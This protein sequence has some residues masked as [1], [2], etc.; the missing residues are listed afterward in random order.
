MSHRCLV[1]FSSLLVIP[2]AYSQTAAPNASP[3]P[4]F[5]SKVRAV[6]VDVVVIG[7]KGEPVLGLHKQDFRV[8]EDGKPQ[9]ISSFEEHTGVPP[10]EVKLP[11][12]PPGVFTNF[13]ALLKADTVNVLLVD[14]LNTQTQ[15]Q[16]FSRSQMIKYLK[17]I[18]PGAHIAIFTLTSQL[19]M[20]QEFTTDSSVLLAALNDPAVAGPHQSPLLQSQ[21]EKDAY[22]RLGAMVALAPSA[23]MQNLAKEA[24]NPA[25]AVKQMLEETVVRITESR[26][27]ITL[28][29]M[30]QLGRYLGSFPGRKN[31]IWISGSFPINFMA[32][33]SLPDPNAVVRGFQGEIQRTAD[34]LTAAQVAV[35]PV[36]AAGLRVDALYQANAKEIGFYSTGGFVQDQVQGLHAGI[37]ERAG[38][39]LTM[40]E[41]AKDTGGQAFYNSNGI[42]DV[43]TR[44]TNNGMR[45]YEISYTSTNTKVDGSYRHISVELLKGKHKLSY[46]RG[47]YALDAAAVRQSELEAAPDPLLPLVGFAVPDVAQILYKLR[48]LPSSPQPAVDATPAGS[49]RDLKGPV[50]RYDVDFAVAPDDLKYDIGPDGTRHGDVEVKLVAYDSSGKPVNMV[51]GRKAMSLDPQTYATLQKVGLQIHEQIDVPSKGDFHLR[52]GIYDLKSSNAGTLGIK[53]KDVAASQQATK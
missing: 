25:L 14:A 51:S 12:M 30:Q 8:T 24:V 36:G 9:T 32:D 1:W 39:D 11:P 22:E 28:R 49:N 3:A 53:M 45:Y 46:R 7:G 16:S 18:P 23:P 33:P 42:N 50:T 43:L 19:R 41:M 37:D 5:E 31:V 20:L 40:E 44:I 47:Y 52:T 2:F 34:L 35:Y 4:T 48:V 17:T 21:V 27:Q 6:L 15:D 10:T 38:N 13:P 26:V 29:A